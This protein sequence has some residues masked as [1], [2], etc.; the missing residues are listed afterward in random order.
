VTEG[1]TDQAGVFHRLPH[2]DDARLAELAQKPM[3]FSWV[4]RW[5][6]GAEPSGDHLRI[7]L[8]LKDIPAFE[9]EEFMP[10]E[11]S[12]RMEVRLFYVA[13][14]VGTPDDYWR[15]ESQNWRKGLEKFVCR[16]AVSDSR[17]DSLTYGF[18]LS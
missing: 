1:G 13:G 2:L 11:S 9:P 12:Q 8:E 16:Q 6:P 4:T 14:T 3:I 5:L 18:C 10:P 17:A 15:E 7:E